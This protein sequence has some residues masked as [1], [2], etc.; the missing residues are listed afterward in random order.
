MSNQ[1]ERRHGALRAARDPHEA[2]EGGGTRGIRHVGEHAAREA[3]EHERAAMEPL[4]HRRHVEREAE[5]EA[6]FIV[7]KRPRFL[8]PRREWIAGVVG[9]LA[10]AL[11]TLLLLAILAQQ[12]DAATAGGAGA[13]SGNITVQVDDGYLT[14]ALGDAVKQAPLPGT[15]SNIRVHADTGDVVR[16]SADLVSLPLAPARRMTATVHLSVREGALHAHVQSLTVGGLA[17]PGFVTGAVETAIN[18]QLAG[19]SAPME[20]GGH[21]YAVAGVQ[22]APGTLTIV[23]RR[24]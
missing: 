6:S 10:G 14:D 19:L 13:T 4:A 2:R 9:L 11:V 24:E 7:A 8:L 17:L 15:V 16:I 18:Q 12:P 22:T 1:Q 5:V 23:L 20:A 21:Q 3:G